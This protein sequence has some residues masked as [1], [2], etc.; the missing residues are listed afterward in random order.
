MTNPNEMR[1]TEMVDTRPLPEAEPVEAKPAEAKPAPEA[2]ASEI[3][4]V[5]RE[6]FVVLSGVK[7]P[8]VSKLPAVVVN[9][10]METFRGVFAAQGD[11]SGKKPS[12]IDPAKVMDLMGMFGSI[13]EFLFKMVRKEYHEALTEHLEKTEPDHEVVDVSELTTKVLGMFSQY[14]GMPMGKALSS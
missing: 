10:M 12:E 3:A 4:P 13:E 14:T 8:C 6:K 7:Y 9:R 5:N 2:K 1:T 11:I